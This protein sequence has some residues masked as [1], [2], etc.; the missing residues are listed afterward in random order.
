MLLQEML[1]SML[2][3]EI[4]GHLDDQERDSGNRKMVKEKSSSKHHQVPLKC[5]HP[6]TVPEVLS[7][8][9]SGSARPLWLKAWRIRSLAFIAWVPAFVISVPI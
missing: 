1:N 7:L 8:K 3:G 6:G 2:E 4:D 9:S 5:L